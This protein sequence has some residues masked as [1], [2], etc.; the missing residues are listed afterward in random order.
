MLAF[1]ETKKAGLFQPKHR[2]S[3]ILAEVIVGVVT[4]P[5][6][7]AFAIASGATPEQGIYTAIVAGFIVLYLGVADFRLRCLQ[8][9]LLL[10]YRQL[11]RNMV[12]KDYK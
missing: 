1:C 11:P 3:N 5:L 10:F 2:L 9:L 7:M 6:A 4:L 12:L 8:V